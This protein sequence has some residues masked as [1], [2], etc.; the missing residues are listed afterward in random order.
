MSQQRDNITAKL[1]RFIVSDLAMDQDLNELDQDDDLL[2]DSIVD[3]LGI[4]RLI[5]FIEEE[6]AFT[7]PSEDVV[8]QHFQTVRAITDYLIPRLSP[9]GD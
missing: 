5:A 3:S 2:E 6:F 4:M 7:V 1:I 9:D 8:I